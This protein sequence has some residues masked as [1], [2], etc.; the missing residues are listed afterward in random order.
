[1]TILGELPLTSGNIK[2]KGRIAYASQE[3]WSFNTSVRNN[4]LFGNAYDEKRYKQVIDVCALERDL[5]LFPF[6]DRTL[7][8]ERGVSLSGG[9]KARITLARY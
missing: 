8:G 3:P 4:I 9:Q 2:T 1:M 5:T 7:V 6:G